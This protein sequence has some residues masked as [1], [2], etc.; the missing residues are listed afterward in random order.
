LGDF[1]WPLG[2]LPG[3]VFAIFDSYVHPRKKFEAEFNVLPPFVFIMAVISVCPV[4]V[5]PLGLLEVD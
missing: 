2:Y 5:M 1:K 3:Q 4:F